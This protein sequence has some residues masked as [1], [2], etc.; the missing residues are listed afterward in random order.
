MARAALTLLFFLT[1]VAAGAV[2][3]YVSPDA[4]SSAYAAGAKAAT[5]R[6]N[7]PR[8]AAVTTDNTPDNRFNAI[9]LTLRSPCVLRKCR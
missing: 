1:A 2:V 5:A 8:A 6:R 4:A 9:S 3:N 7:A